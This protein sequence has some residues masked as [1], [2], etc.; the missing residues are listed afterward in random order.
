M[1]TMK[2]FEFYGFVSLKIIKKPFPRSLFSSQNIVILLSQDDF[3]KFWSEQMADYDDLLSFQFLNVIY[4]NTGKYDAAH[5]KVEE[6]CVQKIPSFLF[7]NN[8]D[9]ITQNYQLTGIKILGYIQSYIFNHSFSFS[10]KSNFD[11]KTIIEIKVSRLLKKKEVISFTLEDALC[12]IGSN[13]S[14]FLVFP[15][16]KILFFSK[17]GIRT[18]YLNDEMLNLINSNIDA[19]TYDYLS[20][21]L[22]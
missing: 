2:I 4:Y 13:I 21:S 9:L 20:Q 6:Q 8:A 12:V 10:E 22:P 7:D 19:V 11:N 16:K 3:K 1:A 5:K 15:Q 14:F 18:V 17:N